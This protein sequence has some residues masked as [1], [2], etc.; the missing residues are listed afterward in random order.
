MSS[1]HHLFRRNGTWSYR[2]RVPTHLVET[3]GKKLIQFSLQT[4]DLKQ[5]KKRRSAEDLKWSTRFEAAEHNLAPGALFAQA[6]SPA[7]A[8]CAPLSEQEVIKLVQ[9]YVEKTDQRSHGNLLRD[10]PES[11]E[12]KADMRADVEMRRQIL[13]NRDDPRADEIV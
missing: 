6:G 2:R 10:P 9:E 4:T 13:R 3:L 12:Q 8:I 1:T 7:P 5:A 11:E